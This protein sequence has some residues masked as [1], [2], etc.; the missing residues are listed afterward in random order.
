MNEEEKLEKLAD[1]FDCDSSELAVD[2]NL[3]ELSWDSMAML[4]V[5][6]IAR[7]NGKVVTGEQVRGFKTVADIITAAF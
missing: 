1:V 6:A 3:D 4:T 7:K 5:I 2:K